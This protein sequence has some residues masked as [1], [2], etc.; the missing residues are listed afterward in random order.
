MM[1]GLLCC[2]TSLAGAALFIALDMEHGTPVSYIGLGGTMLGGATLGLISTRGWIHTYKA[3]TDAVIKKEEGGFEMSSR[4]DS[5][6]YLHTFNNITRHSTT[7]H[8]MS[9]A[10]AANFNRN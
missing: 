5:F 10:C 7:A 2:S 9:R 6:F 1:P 8:I 4:V 3:L